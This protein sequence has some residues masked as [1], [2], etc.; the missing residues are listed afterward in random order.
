MTDRGGGG[1]LRSTELALIQQNR[2]QLCK[3]FMH[4]VLKL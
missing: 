4:I 3:Y 1:L 2:L